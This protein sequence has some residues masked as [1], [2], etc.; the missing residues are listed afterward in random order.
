[1]SKHGNVSSFG[2]IVFYWGLLTS[3]L[4]RYSSQEVNL[5]I[6]RGGWIGPHDRGGGGDPHF[7][8]MSKNQKR[9]N[10][11][12]GGGQSLFGHSPKFYIFISPPKKIQ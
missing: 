4:T 2:T 9:L 10:H 11:L 3:S 6:S 7:S 5:F 12:G 8:K 1:M